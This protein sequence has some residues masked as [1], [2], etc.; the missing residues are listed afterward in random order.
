VLYG[1]LALMVRIDVLDQAYLLQEIC[2][3]L[4]RNQV[5]QEVGIRRHLLDGIQ[6]WDIDLHLL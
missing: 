6:K 2:F 5:L 1:Q 3:P 4:D